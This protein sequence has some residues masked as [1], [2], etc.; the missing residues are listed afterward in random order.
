MATVHRDPLRPQVILRNNV[1]YIS[2]VLPDSEVQ[3]AVSIA[4]EKLMKRILIVLKKTSKT[5]A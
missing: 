5:A 2:Q 3:A 4:Y 1:S